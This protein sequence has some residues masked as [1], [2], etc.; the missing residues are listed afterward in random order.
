[1]S[2]RN[3]KKNAAKTPAV[4]ETPVVGIEAIVTHD[5]SGAPLDLEP[6]AEDVA[7][8]EADYITA[9]DAD[10]MA[11]FAEGDDTAIDHMSSDTTDPTM[12]MGEDGNE[13]V[14]TTE[15]DLTLTAS[16][17]ATE[18][19]SGETEVSSPEAPEG[20]VHETEAVDGE[21]Q[22]TL[23]EVIAAIDEEQAKTYALQVGT[24]L[25]DREA[26]EK[27]RPDYKDRILK[28]LDKARRNLAT[29]R[30]A[31]VL[32]AA[33][34]DPNFLN[35]SVHE[36]ARYNVYALDKLSDI[37]NGLITGNEVGNAIN[38]ACMVS[39]FRARANGVTWNMKLAKAAASKQVPVDS[40]VKKWLLRHTVS[41]STAP[42]QASS[43]MQ[44]L[45]TIGIVSAVGSVKDP[46]YVILD[47]P[48]ARAA[49]QVCKE[50][51]E[52]LAAAA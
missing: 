26:F 10:A 47:T 31:R 6:S 20:E 7:A 51:T 36:G 17:E 14:D 8:A 9:D 13:L 16:D 30:A 40:A 39:M 28:S 22:Q 44:A 35:R 5:L 3:S 52:G 18:A 2:K 46:S 32:I 33:G 25:S 48:M 38:R 45:A 49:E 34:V 29:V 19:G 4:T 43:T 23:S 11:R 21:Q 50:I 37:V 41:P 12:P 15:V 42:T 27:A 24:A 1:M